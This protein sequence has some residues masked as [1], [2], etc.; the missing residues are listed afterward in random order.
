M[1]ADTG[2]NGEVPAPL[3]GAPTPPRSDLRLP[4]AVTEMADAALRPL[5]GSLGPDTHPFDVIT[6]VV[7][8]YESKVAN[9]FAVDAHTGRLWVGATAPDGEDGAVDG[10]SD[11]AIAAGDLTPEQWS[12]LEG[13]FG[14]AEEA[15]AMG[16]LGGAA[17][18]LG[19]ACAT[20]V[21]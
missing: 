17:D 15:L 1:Q 10:V 11:R 7:L 5:M 8:G 20:F 21:E 2:R 13:F 6:S 12:A 16:D 14:A 18:L 19:S 4:E 9:Y 3:C